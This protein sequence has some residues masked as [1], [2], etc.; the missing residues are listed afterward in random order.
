MPEQ[1]RGEECQQEQKSTALPPP[2]KSHSCHPS[3]VDFATNSYT[4]VHY[5][6]TKR[7]VLVPTFPLRNP[8]KEIREADAEPRGAHEMRIGKVQPTTVSLTELK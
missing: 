1:Y 5:Y 3:K 8:C 4:N 2:S 7:L 6:F